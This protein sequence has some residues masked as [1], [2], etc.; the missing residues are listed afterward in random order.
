MGHGSDW[1]RGG[2]HDDGDEGDGDEG[3][4]DEDDGRSDDW[5]DAEFDGD[6]AEE[7]A[8]A[9][10]PFC[11]REILEDAPRCPHCE[12][13]LTDEDHA[14][15]RTPR[16]VLVTAILCLAAAVWMALAAI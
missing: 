6:E 9:P 8:T 5:S 16:W 3:E 11:R 2:W 10:C 1:N 4:V 15:S 7:P 12:R 14:R 13:Y